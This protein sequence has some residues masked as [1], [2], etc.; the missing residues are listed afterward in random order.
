LRAARLIPAAFVAGAIVALTGSAQAPPSLHRQS[1]TLMGTLCEVQVYHA[2][3]RV[4]ETAIT[5]ALDEMQRV[6]RLLSNHDPASELSAMNREAAKAP[7]RASEELFGFVRRSQDFFKETQG[8]F[9]PTVGPL[10]RAW[11]FFGPRPVR[12]PDAAIAAA[13]ASSGFSKV[14]LDASARTVFYAAPGLE[15]D[16]GGIGKGYAVDKAVKALG[17]ADITSALVSAG[18]STIF[19]IGHPPGRDRWRL[20]VGD[21]DDV[22]R[23]IRY[24]HLRD[25]AVSTSGVAQRSIRETTRRYSHVFDPRSG[26]PVE[27]MCQASVVT[28]TATDSDA[29]TKAAYVLDRDAVLRLFKERGERSH[30]LRVEGA[31]GRES[32]VWV[33]PWSTGTFTEPSREAAP[34]ALGAAASR[35]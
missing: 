32:T 34:F 12:P 30:A 2:D 23:P 5:R 31:C 4:A 18:G 26:E 29:L 19:A 16:P 17:Q 24:V 15:F 8:A 33:T 35:R 25:A 9:D 27:N 13:K 14:I 28:T 1:R 20:G 3:A 10:V 7:F 6:D 21:P 11:G 22:E